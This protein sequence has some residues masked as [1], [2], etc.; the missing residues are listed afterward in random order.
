MLSLQSSKIILLVRLLFF[1]VTGVFKLSL[2]NHV[3]LKDQ[4]KYFQCR[5]QEVKTDIEKDQ[6]YDIGESET[7]VLRKLIVFLQF[8]FVQINEHATLVLA[9]FDYIIFSIMHFILHDVQETLLNISSMHIDQNKTMKKIRIKISIKL[10]YRRYMTV[11]RKRGRSRK[12]RRC[13]FKQKLC[14]Y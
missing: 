13:S 3:N 4:I 14:A 6:K 5:K 2:K 12:N 9:G 11:H 10:L 7:I 1:L 8:L